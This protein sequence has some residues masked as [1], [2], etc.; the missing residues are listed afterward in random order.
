MII[1]I[2]TFIQ[3]GSIGSFFVYLFRGCM[4]IYDYFSFFK[5]KRNMLPKTYKATQRESLLDAFKHFA[6][7]LGFLAVFWLLYETGL[8]EYSF[9]YLLEESGY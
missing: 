1:L 7:S 9:F 8:Y 5:Y 2:I 4:R 3:L 6:S